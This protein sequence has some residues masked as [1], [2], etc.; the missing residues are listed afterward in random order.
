MAKNIVEKEWKGAEKDTYWLTPP[1]NTALELYR[2]FRDDYDTYYEFVKNKYLT[3]HWLSLLEDFI[4]SSSSSDVR[5]IDAGCGSLEKEGWLPFVSEI[6]SQLAK[7]HGKN[8]I[9]YGVDITPLPE[10]GLLEKYVESSMSDTDLCKKLWE[11]FVCDAVLAWNSLSYIDPKQFEQYIKNIST[12]LCAW[13]LFAATFMN[14]ENPEWSSEDWIIEC[15][16]APWSDEKEVSV[17]IY[18]DPENKNGEKVILR[19]LYIH[20]R[21][22]IKKYLTEYGFDLTTL[23]IQ[24]VENNN[25]PHLGNNTLVGFSI[26]KR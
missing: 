19:H 15:E 24:S 7:K 4:S 8:L 1:P 20:D 16:F 14:P 2:M 23:D 13:W 10:Q 12:V 18:A 9:A 26:K 21:D 17:T 25:P 11:G 22:M 3:D 5:I 6:S